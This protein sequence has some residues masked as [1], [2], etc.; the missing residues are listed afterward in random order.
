MSSRERVRALPWA[1]VLQAGLVI[2]RRWR[3]L[4]ANDRAR[5]ARL[6]RDAGGRPSNLRPKERK[7]LRKLAGKL[8]LKGA[9][10]ELL[11][12]AGSRRGR[13]G[14]RRCPVP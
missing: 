5:M 1:L 2:G 4:S 8:D 10:R 7:E 3:A 11:S 14:R 13:R 9:S 12:L 6:L